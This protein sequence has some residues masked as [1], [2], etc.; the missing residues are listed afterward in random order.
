MDKRNTLKTYPIWP[1]PEDATSFD[2]NE[3]YSINLHT[4]EIK[5]SLKIKVKKMMQQASTIWWNFIG[6]T[7]VLNSL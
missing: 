4:A 2:G 3:N 7:M 6:A 1:Y 5:D